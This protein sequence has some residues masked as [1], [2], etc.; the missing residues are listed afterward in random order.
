MDTTNQNWT[1]L[2]DRIVHPCTVS[3]AVES[4][5]TSASSR[6]SMWLLCLAVCWGRIWPL[7]MVGHYNAAG[8][9]VQND[10]QS[11]ESQ[12]HCIF[13]ESYPF[14]CSLF[15]G[16]LSLQ[17]IHVPRQYSVSHLTCHRQKEE[18]HWTGLH[19]VNFQLPQKLRSSSFV[20]PPPNQKAALEMKSIYRLK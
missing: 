20:L 15:L 8:L 4:D 7:P 16:S 18:N 5:E 19:S 17:S 3:G 10:Q 14:L 11:S 1:R 13:Q 2:S 9:R 12:H 6:R